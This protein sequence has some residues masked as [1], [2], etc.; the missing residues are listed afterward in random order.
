M[1]SFH[2]EDIVLFSLECELHALMGVMLD[3]RKWCR[4]NG[5]STPF[6]D[7]CSTHEYWRS[8]ACEPL[9]T[10]KASEVLAVMKGFAVLNER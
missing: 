4:A 7:R 2:G 8:S 1:S 6:G 5:S 9:R 10:K 3:A